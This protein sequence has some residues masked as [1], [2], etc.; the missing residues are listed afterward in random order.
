MKLLRASL[1]LG[2]LLGLLDACLV[3]AMTPMTVGGFSDVA[4]MLLLSSVTYAVVALFA[5]ALTGRACE[6]LLK[7]SSG[8]SR[9]EVSAALASAGSIFLIGIYVMKDLKGRGITQ[10][11]LPS[12]VLLVSAVAGLVACVVIGLYRLRHAGQLG[13]ARSS[14]LA[15]VLMLF[16]F[17]VKTS[18]GGGDVSGKKNVVL[19]SV[20]TLRAD[21]L[22]VYGYERETSPNIDALAEGAVVFEEAFSSSHWTFPSHASLLTGLDPV[23]LGALSTEDTLQPEYKTLAETLKEN[24]WQTAAFVGGGNY[25]YISSERG[26]GQGFNHYVH[27]PYAHEG[28]QS[29]VLSW[30]SH[31]WS[32]KVEHEIGTAT[33]QMA[34][35]ER[36]LKSRSDAPFFLF[37]H[38]YD[39]HSDKYQLPYDAPGEFRE[40]FTSGVGE[41][42]TG[43]H[44]SGMC[45]SEMLMAYA[46]GEIEGLPSEDHIKRMI[47]LYDGGIA[48]ADAEL[49][50]FFSALERAGISDSTTLVITSDHGEAFFE[51]GLPLHEDLHH[52]NLHVPLILKDPDLE[53]RRLRG[54][55]QNMDIVPA[56]LELVGVGG[57][58]RSSLQQLLY[59]EI[60]SETARA[61]S[62]SS[63]E[64]ALTTELEKLIVPWD[65]VGVESVDIERAVRFQRG[66]DLKETAALSGA[67][68]AESLE[69]LLGVTDQSVDVREAI[70]PTGERS[71]HESSEAQ[72]LELRALGYVD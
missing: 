31:R 19:I 4:L 30:L 63:D 38:L 35:V 22:G 48:Y 70:I 65:G 40:R 9:R 71:Q 21:H 64:V 8:Q 15:L 59:G 6:L 11:G 27:A 12:S 26:F 66:P 46:R 5:M 10:V 7:K 29:L 57:H 41:D 47:D 1:E 36:W 34:H 44:P 52:E 49:L 23:A 53:P 45:A 14:G 28:M 68:A 62:V 17:P 20:D 37:L 61:Y 58:Q 18:G 39:V 13:V 43:C 25:S 42:F 32:K 16:A 72:R 69:S 3:R 67:E 60:T 2:L 33:S 54:A 50:R 55:V 56:I 51:H 24:G